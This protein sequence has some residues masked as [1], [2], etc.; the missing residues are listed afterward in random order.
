MS[1]FQKSP[2]PEQERNA[3]FARL[4]ACSVQH[5]G[6]RAPLPRAAMSYTSPQMLWYRQPEVWYR[7][8]PK[9][10]WRLSKASACGQPSSAR[11]MH[12]QQ[13]TIMSNMG[14]MPRAMHESLRKANF[15][16]GWTPPPNAPAAGWGTDLIRQTQRA[17]L[18]TIL[19]GTFRESKG[20]SQEELADQ[21]WT[22]IHVR[23]STKSP[24][25]RTKSDP[26]SVGDPKSRATD[27]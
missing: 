13:R 7:P 21:R 23:E 17:Q 1:R 24:R 11:P 20:F 5:P 18:S 6:A 10:P 22:T 4:R 19:G 14:E 16:P 2:Q 9:D 8:Q 3:K 12:M 27:E 25:P 26:N 15:V